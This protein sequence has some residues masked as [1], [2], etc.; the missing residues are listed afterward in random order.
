MSG[1][2]TPE[3][4][5]AAVIATAEDHLSWL[6]PDEVKRL[7]RVYGAPSVLR[8][9]RLDERDDAIRTLAAS[10][11]AGDGLV[12]AKAVG[13]KLDRPSGNPLATHAADLCG[14]KIPSKFQLKSILAG[15]RR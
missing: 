15:R 14:G 6:D 11:D 8:R 7:F 5:R 4:W 3:R 1:A 2:L 10:L 13:A 9:R 12:L